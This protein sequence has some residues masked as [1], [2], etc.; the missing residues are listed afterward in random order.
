MIDKIVA[1]LKEPDIV[2]GPW[3]GTNPLYRS[4]NTTPEAFLAQ[5]GFKQRGRPHH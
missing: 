4:R 5:A 3:M 1:I 2:E